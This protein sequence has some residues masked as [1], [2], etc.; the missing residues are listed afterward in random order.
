MAKHV[1]V[2]L[3][4]VK[5]GLVLQKGDVVVDAT[6]GL[7]G[8]AQEILKHI[9]PGG[10][11]YGFDKDEDALKEAQKVLSKNKKNYALIEGG[12]E[13]M[14][15]VLQEK[16]VRTVDKILFDLGYSSLQVD[17]TE[18]GFSFKDT[19]PLDMRFSKHGVVTAYDVVNTWEEQT[20]ADIIY[21]FGEERYARRIAKNIVEK[22]KESP[23]ETTK[24]LAAIVVESVPF[25]YRHRKIHPATKTFQAIRIAV[26]EELETI[27]KT[28]PIAFSI[29]KKEGRL[30]VITFHSLEDRIVKQ[31]FKQKKEEGKA[32]IHTKKPIT[33]SEKEVKVNPRSRS[34][35]LRILEK[36]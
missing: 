16:G 22:R 19:A 3:Q 23:I 4:E 7:G 9:V 11:L 27:K 31:F 13:D 30:A 34:A 2:L 36:L 25:T 28:L 32:I 1:P 17:N 5:N 14:R 10:M 35:K 12:Y 6:V 26:N 18:R 29:L 33:A 8:H 15:K 20:L 21:G 24:D